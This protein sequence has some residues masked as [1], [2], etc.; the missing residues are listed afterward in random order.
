MW[1]FLLAIILILVTCGSGKEFDWVLFAII[2]SPIWGYLLFGILILSANWLIE[3][4]A[5]KK[6]FWI[7]L[8]ELILLISVEI[9]IHAIKSLVKKFR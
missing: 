9:P 3:N 1:F 6:K 2:T 7:E 5:Y 8:W 4:E